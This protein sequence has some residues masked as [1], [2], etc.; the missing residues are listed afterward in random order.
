MN[1]T[2][3]NPPSSVKN[4]SKEVIQACVITIYQLYLHNQ[5]YLTTKTISRAYPHTL[6]TMMAELE[7][8]GVVDKNHVPMAARGVNTAKWIVNGG[9]FY[10]TADGTHPS[11]AADDLMNTE[12]QPVLAAVTVT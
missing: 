9:A 7:K 10:A 12:F 2:I 11:V 1:C 4:K 3:D 6:D 5:N 8:Y